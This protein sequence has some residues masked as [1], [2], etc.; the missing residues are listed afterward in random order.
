MD[1][2]LKLIFTQW[3]DNRLN[4]VNESVAYR[5][6]CDENTHTLEEIEANTDLLSNALYEMAERAFIAGFNTSAELNKLLDGVTIKGE[7]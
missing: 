3:Q 2:I 5:R 1:G 4:G 6:F 7:I